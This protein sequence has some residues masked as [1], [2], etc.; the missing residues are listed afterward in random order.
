MGAAILLLITFPVVAGLATLAFRSR[1]PYS[2]LWIL[3]LMAFVFLA[4][5]AITASA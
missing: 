4:G 3:V 1:F 5:S 2:V